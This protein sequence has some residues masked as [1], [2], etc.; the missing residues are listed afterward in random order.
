MTY[1]E[2]KLQ[3][4]KLAT[5]LAELGVKKGDRVATVLP[6]C[7]QFI[8]SDY[9]ILKIGAVH[10]PISILHKYDDLV[11]EI[12]ESGAETVICS[13]R[14]IELVKSVMEKVKIRTIIYTPVPIFPDYKMPEMEE[15]S[16]AHQLETL[17]EK[18]E[19]NPPTIEINPEEDL[20]LV[21]FTGGTTGLPKGTMLTH[22]NVTT[23]VIQAMHWMMA[24][25]LLGLKGK[26]SVL[27]CIPMFHQFGHIAQ[28]TAI[29]L[30]LRIFLVDPRD[31]QR[32]VNITTKHRPFIVLG[33]PTHFM[34]M[35][36]HELPRMQIFMLSAAAALP[37]EVAEGIE[38]KIGVP[39]GEGYGLT[40]ATAATH[41]NLSAF[42]KVTGFAAKVKRSIGVPIPDTEIR[43]VN[44][45][46]GEDAPF[47]E[48]GELWIRGPQIMKGYWRT[49]GKGLEDGWLKTGD[50]AK[51]D[52]DGYFYIVDRIKDMINVSGMKV[53]SRVI[54][55]A[56]YEHPAVSVVG[57]IGVPDPDRLGSERVK[58]FIQL[59]PNYEGKVT[60]QDIINFCKEKVPPYA[61]PKFVEFRKKLPVTLAMKIHKKKLRDEELAKVK[62]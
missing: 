23:N 60:E 25:L 51:M 34:M 61:V 40:E 22:Y 36:P 45:D 53:Y 15:V 31:I 49:P 8:V 6:N 37:P 41:L 10:I 57:V 12:G 4:D 9:A 16:D 46:T 20:A 13:Y 56:L 32:I 3:V 14:R 26:S 44:V 59:K 62:K 27:L 43:I 55:D 29:S 18:Y 11:H 1:K 52:E 35:L 50:I 21:P 7:P 48:T 58:A 54:D 2:L 24:P 33:V 17:L 19:P 47:G 39:M 28:F 5:A 38:K 42:S 30:G